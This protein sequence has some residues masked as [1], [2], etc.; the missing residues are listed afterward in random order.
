MTAF[1]HFKVPGA[2]GAL[3][4]LRDVAATGAPRRVYLFAA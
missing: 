4:L 3:Q 2:H 1:L